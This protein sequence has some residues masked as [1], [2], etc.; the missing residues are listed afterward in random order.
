MEI[1]IGKIFRAEIEKLE[2]LNKVILIFFLTT[3][4]IFCQKLFLHIREI[5]RVELF[6]FE[7]FKY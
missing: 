4:I 3:N 5:G 6:I 1:N 7:K 2:K